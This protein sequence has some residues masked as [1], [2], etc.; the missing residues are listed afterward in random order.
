MALK[1][2]VSIVMPSHNREKFIGEAIDSMLCQTFSDFELII[3]DDGSDDNT[4]LEIKK[5][6]DLRIKVLQHEVNQGNYVARNTGMAIAKGR[7][8]AVMDSDDIALP[9]RLQLQ[10]D[11]LNSHPKVGCV[12]ALA[13]M[14]YENGKP[15]KLIRYPSSY[16]KLKTYLFRTMSLSHPTIIDVGGLVLPLNKGFHMV[17][18]STV[19]L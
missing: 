19:T 1:P 8:I 13:E 9:N 15:F 17:M 11:F 6:K 3:V 12:G 2:L 5:F 16:S 7:Y 14:I 10:V 18:S 4:L